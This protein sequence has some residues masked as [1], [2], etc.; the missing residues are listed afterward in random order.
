ME[1]KKAGIDAE[2]LQDIPLAF[3]FNKL[4][5]K[6]Y[7]AA[8]KLFED[9]DMDRNFF[10]LNLIGSYEQVTQQCLADYL[11]MD[12]AAIVRIIDYL[13]E[14]G[15]VKRVANATDRRQ[16][17]IVTTPKAADYVAKISKG[18]ADINKI[19]FKGF[20]RQEKTDFETMVKK[21][22]T[23]LAS[24]PSEQYSLKYIKTKKS[25]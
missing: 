18:F 8:G 3:V 11:Q 12:K 4:A 13:T 23:N 25:K 17:N 15:L 16:Y 1:Q 5:K 19:A 7:G 14:K 24:L 21:M 22:Q 20:S 2:K 9:L 10:V 6:Y